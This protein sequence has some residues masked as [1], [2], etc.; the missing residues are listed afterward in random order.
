V[1]RGRER[2]T[3]GAS[4]ARI[5]R[6]NRNGR[7]FRAAVK[8]V[9]LDPRTPD[10][11]VQ[12]GSSPVTGLGEEPPGRPRADQGALR[13][14]GDHVVPTGINADRRLVTARSTISKNSGGRP[15]R[16]CLHEIVNRVILVD[17]ASQDETTTLRLQ[18]GIT[19]VVH[20]RNLGYGGTRRPATGGAPRRADVVIMVHPDYH[21]TP[22]ARD[23]DASMVA[24]GYLRHGAWVA[25]M[26]G[27]SALK[28][29][30]TL[31]VR[32]E[33]DLTLIENRELQRKLS[34]YHTG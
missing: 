3:P 10:A 21:T 16:S 30:A 33:P 31:Q 22:R 9:A 25:R 11:R 18:L 2:A 27:T 23:R 24:E 17:D 5:S 32:R 20:P 28:G 1:R 19:T 26:L 15:T 34:E 6:V 13:A 4:S 8:S 7:R 14:T 29:D 12:P